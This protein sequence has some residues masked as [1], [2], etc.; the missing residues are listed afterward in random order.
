MGLIICRRI[1]ESI[2]VDGP[3]TITNLGHGKSKQQFIWRIEGP[4]TTKVL[5]QELVEQQQAQ[6]RQ[7][8]HE[9]GE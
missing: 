3:C 9:A 4:L 1:G 5:R 7:A 2:V 6:G 8:G